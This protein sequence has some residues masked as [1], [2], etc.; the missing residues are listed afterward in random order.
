[1]K[2]QAKRLLLSKETLAPLEAGRLP[3]AA[4]GS[5]SANDGCSHPC[6]VTLTCRVCPPA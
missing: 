5:I 6:P 4:G 1:M 3:P 2:K